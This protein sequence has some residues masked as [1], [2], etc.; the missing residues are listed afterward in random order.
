MQL[1][2]AA[3]VLWA[4]GFIE[5]AALLL[6]LLGRGRWRSYPIFTVWIG[7]QMA[8]T[9]VL[10]SLYRHIIYTSHA[11]YALVYWGTAA[12]DLVLQIA[13]V[14]ELAGIVLK[15]TGTW[16]KDAR[17]MFLL[18][19]GVGTMIAAAAAYGI[20]PK[21]PNDL[22]GWIDK[23]SLFAA[24][25]NAQLFAAM[26]FASTRLGLAWRHHVMAIAS[27]WA[28]W[29]VVGLFVEAAHSYL[30][31]DWHGVSLDQVRILAYQAVTVYWTIN[32]WLPEPERRT[33]SAEMQ[34]YLAGIHQ[35]A[36]LGV[37]SMSRL[38]R[39]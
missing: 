35:Q 38:D 34:A 5:L 19:V 9:L 21:V 26:T 3:R 39:R 29:A 8:R 25:L 6:V 23:G 1:S 30:G 18:L 33:L 27:G 24:M 15:P 14:F 22:G 20:A 36:Q 13:I 17:R 31:P 12:L 28:L 10:F 2:L 16:V 37:H 4:A 32:L 7:F 11:T